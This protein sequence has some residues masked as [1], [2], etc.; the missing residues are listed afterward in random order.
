VALYDRLGV[1][2]VINIDTPDWL[3]R[4]MGPA[5]IGFSSWFFGQ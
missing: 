1:G 5:L 2:L 3:L 4:Q